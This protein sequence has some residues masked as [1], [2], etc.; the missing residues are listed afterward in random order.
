LL[1]KPVW[2]AEK[3]L[4]DKQWQGEILYPTVFNRFKCTCCFTD[5]MESCWCHLI[6]FWRI[7]LHSNMP[8]FIFLFIFLSSWFDKRSADVFLR[9]IT[10]YNSSQWTL[11]R[12]PFN[13]AGIIAFQNNLCCCILLNHKLCWTLLIRYEIEN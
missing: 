11:F 9:I 4:L 5:F 8:G 1:I 10:F 13:Q 2:T 6:E 12:L 7:Q 3:R